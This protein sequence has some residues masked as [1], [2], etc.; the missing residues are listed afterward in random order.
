MVHALLVL[1]LLL[2]FPSLLRNLP[3]EVR[4]SS[5]SAS[6]QIVP[7]MTC[8][9]PVPDQ[10]ATSSPDSDMNVN[11][12]PGDTDPFVSAP[13]ARL[14]PLV[15]PKRRRD[16][17]P[18]SHS[19]PSTVTSAD[20]PSNISVSTEYS[21]S[22]VAPVAPVEESSNVDS[23]Q[24]Q[25]A[26]STPDEFSSHS[27]EQ[28]SNV[29]PLHPDTFSTS[30]THFPSP[31]RDPFMSFFPGL[32]SD[33]PSFDDPNCIPSAFIPSEDLCDWSTDQ[34]GMYTFEEYAQMLEREQPMPHNL[35]DSD[36]DNAPHFAAE[37]LPSRA[38]RW[39]DEIFAAIDDVGAAIEATRPP[40]LLAMAV[41]SAP[42]PRNCTPPPP[43]PQYPAARRRTHQ[44][45]SV[46]PHQT[47]QPSASRHVRFETLPPA[48]VPPPTNTPILR[49]LPTP[50]NVSPQRTHVSPQKEIQK[51]IDQLTYYS[52]QR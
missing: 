31:S 9:N 20:P 15:P 47:T 44:S 49:K 29:N 37:E 39:F 30:P 8:P 7:I 2:V 18:D 12:N 46:Q 23:N 32:S 34:M 5:L 50:S 45:S 22:P 14:V 40:A 41:G 42:P 36:T 21:S 10:T 13:Q 52:E 38:T 16:S 26:T 6:I 24:S 25:P 17:T 3:K 27:D 11:N 1:D 19:L 4:R 48:P 43:L 28:C 33:A 51:E 35:A